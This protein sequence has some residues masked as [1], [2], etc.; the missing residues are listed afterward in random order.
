MTRGR[1]SRMRQ[2]NACA[3]LRAQRCFSVQ[4]GLLAARSSRVGRGHRGRRP[5]VSPTHQRLALMSPPRLELWLDVGRPWAGEPL[6]GAARASMRGKSYPRAGSSHGPVPS[7][8][9]GAGTEDAMRAPTNSERSV[10][11]SV[12]T[13]ILRAPRPR[14][15]GQRT[16]NR[17]ARKPPVRS[18][19]PWARPLWG[20]RPPGRRSRDPTGRHQR[21]RPVRSRPVPPR[22]RDRWSSDSSAEE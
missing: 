22:R 15:R 18:R 7:A 2:H 17:R 3:G 19:P 5:I 9:A 4:S 14:L 11:G 12:R 6:H 20:Q 13:V 21:S 1:L 16:P 8:C 10:S